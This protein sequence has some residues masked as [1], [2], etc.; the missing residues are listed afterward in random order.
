ME[1]VE[2]EHVA[3]PGQADVSSKQLQRQVWPGD[4]WA[5]FHQ[6]QHS[7]IFE[8][9]ALSNVL[10]VTDP[11]VVQCDTDGAQDRTHTGKE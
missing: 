2:W 3:G 10:S 4:R 7:T 9:I 5:V 11:G 6:I 1:C 8:S